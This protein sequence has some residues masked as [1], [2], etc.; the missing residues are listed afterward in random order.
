MPKNSK[1]LKRA[2][3]GPMTKPSAKLWQKSPKKTGPTMFIPL[4]VLETA[5]FVFVSTFLFFCMSANPKGC[6][7]SQV[8][9][10]K[11]YEVE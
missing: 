3:N 10:I 5:M 1:N 2:E 4:L 8:L 9:A 7:V 6:M 11:S